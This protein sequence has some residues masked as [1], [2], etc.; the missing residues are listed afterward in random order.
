L[1]FDSNSIFEDQLVALRRDSRKHGTTG[2]EVDFALL[3]DGLE[4]ERQQGITIDVAYRS[5]STTQRAFVV[6]DSPGHEQYTRNMATAASTAELA[7]ILVDA[8]KG[9]LTQTRRHSYICSLLGIRSVILAINK[10]DLVDFSESVF[11]RLTADFL[12]FTDRLGFH[13]V[14]AIPL[15]GRYGDN[16]VKQSAWMPWYAGPTLLDCL[17]RA[18]IDDR[19]MGKPL[20]FPVQLICRPNS[21]FRGV[22]GTVISGELVAGDRVVVAASGRETSV[23][24]IVSFDGDKERA[25]AGDSI[26]LV[27]NDE[28]D[29]SRGDVLVSPAARPAVADQ[30]AC[31]LIWMDVDHMLPGRSYLLRTGTKTV[32]A[33]ITTLKYSIDVNTLERRPSRTLGLNEIGFC[34][35]ATS[36][37]IAFDPYQESRGTGSFILIDR[38]TNAT[39]GAGMISFPLRRATNIHHQ[40]HLISKV[41]HANLKHQK[42][43]IVW[44]TGLSGS[45]KSAIANLVEQSLHERGFHTFLLDG[46]NIRHGLNRDLGFTDAD[47]VENIRRVGEVAKLLLDA[48]LIAICCFISPFRAERDA[49]R[50]L[51]EAGEFVEVFVDTPLEEC[52]KRDPKGLYAAALAG[53]IKNFTGI[54]SPYETPEAPDIRIEGESAAD[55]AE[56]IGKWLLPRISQE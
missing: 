8:R 11:N 32:P 26:T 33:R 45:G 22:A 15:S 31:H 50:E 4:D 54:D 35:I 20:R 30:F 3:L 13:N 34:N 49:L 55:A 40:D 6:A 7:V 23:Q 44:F 29:I 2:D 5:F 28:V 14:A 53:N 38:L 27:L 17:E 24:R 10:M 39:A 47:R 16:V 9:V 41:R 48:G 52:I 56:R 43:L 25:V 1:L 37:P 46:D 12:E 51:V 21:D 36:S 18:E 19:S 42:P